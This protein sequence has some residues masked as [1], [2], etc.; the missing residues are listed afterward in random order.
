MEKNNLTLC[1]IVKNE[2]AGL[3]RAVESARDQ[4]GQ[5]IIAVDIESDDDTIKIARELTPCVFF[6]RFNNDYS[7]ARNDC[8]K[9]AQTDW[10]LWLDG[11]EFLKEK[12]ELENLAE[13]DK[14]GIL[15]RCELEN[16][17][18]FLTPRILRR[19]VLF[20]GAIHEAPIMKNPGVTATGLIKH[21]RPGG[22]TDESVLKR[23]KQREKMM[24]EIMDKNLKK[25]K[26]D[27]RAALHLGIHYQS[28]GNPKKAVKYYKHFLRY[29]Q[30][31]NDIFIACYQLALC[32]MQD[33]KLNDAEKI[34]KYGLEKCGEMWELNFTMA[35]IKI[36]QKKHIEAIT[37]LMKS[38]EPNTKPQ[39]YF[40]I[41]R[42]PARMWDQIANEF[43]QMQ[44]FE[45]A[46]SAWK[47]A[48]E[49]ID[50]P[51]AKDLWRER[52]ELM[53]KIAAAAVDN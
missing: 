4:V 16:E 2:A 42:Q 18:T 5:I 3:K 31:E 20:E 40:P 44:E 24:V 1:M 6:F 30:D 41:K 51:V 50:D 15:M 36:Q 46:A 49:L 22:Q 7:Q 28:T 39:R 38:Q 26:H 48:S 37:L 34:T 43:F 53:I 35:M 8:A 19:G 47:R 17:M 27:I 11:H 13:T 9:A 29:C 25:N 14:D 21:D 32:Y 52:Y 45:K 12:I 23:N 10:I 33:K